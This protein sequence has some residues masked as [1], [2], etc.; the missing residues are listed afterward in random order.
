M[1]NIPRHGLEDMD[2]KDNGIS[3]TTAIACAIIVIL[4]FGIALS[5][6]DDDEDDNYGGGGHGVHFSTGSSSYSSESKSWYNSSSGS[7]FSKSGY[8]SSSSHSGG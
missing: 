7:S 2:Y 1:N 6:C 3:R 4:T 5:S 8:S